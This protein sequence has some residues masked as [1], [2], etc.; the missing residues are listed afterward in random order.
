MIDANQRWKQQFADYKEALSQL[1]KFIGKD[2]LSDLE[3]QG[4]IQAFV[5]TH[6]LAWYVLR[7]YL[8]DQ[9]TQNI[10]SSSDATRVAFSTNLIEDGEGW[11]DMIKDRNQTIHSYKPTVTKAIIGN[12]KT[13]FFPLF[14]TLRDKM[15]KLHDAK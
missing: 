9:G 7:D 8:R 4:L 5:Y 12:I 10:H 1:T 14:V 13:K 11:M 6:E 2:N 15:Q 3:E